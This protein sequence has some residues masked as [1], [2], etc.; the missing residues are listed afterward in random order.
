MDERRGRWVDN[1]AVQYN[2]NGTFDLY[3]REN[4]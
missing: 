4:A 2:V 1:V 3:H